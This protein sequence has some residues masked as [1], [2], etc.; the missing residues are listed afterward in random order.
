[1]AVENPIYINQFNLSWPDGLDSKS[2]GDDHIRNIKGAIKRTFPNI[3]GEVTATQAQL[4]KLSLPGTVNEP[5]M[6]MIWCHGVATVP[7][8]WKICNGV[9]TISNGRQVPDLTDRFPV[10]GNGVYPLGVLGGSATHTHTAGTVVSGTALTE[11]Q[12]PAH[13]HGVPLGSNDT[14]GSGWTQASPGNTSGVNSPNYY[15]PTQAKGGSQPHAHNATTS[16][17][18]GS[19]LPPYYPVLFIIKD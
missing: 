14:T 1:M 8:G 18:A 3:T 6:V 17:V 16:I 13:T 10:G 4:N 2:Q 11:A 7:V 12:I 9:G 5:G 19:S 15:T